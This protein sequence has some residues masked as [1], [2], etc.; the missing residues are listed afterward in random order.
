[1]TAGSQFG[2]LLRIARQTKGLSR[3]ELARM[4]ALDPSYL[5]RLETGERLPSRQA[6][7]ALADAL[8]L[9]EPE[10]QDWLMAAGYAPM[11]V[12]GLIQGIRTRGGSWRAG[13]PEQPVSGWQVLAMRLE[14]LG[15]NAATTGRLL[16][17]F[18]QADLALQDDAASWVSNAIA[19]VI[20]VLECPIRSAVIPIAG[21]NERLLA[22]HI[23]Q[24]LL[25]HV[26]AEAAEIGVTEV[27][28]VL[29]PGSREALFEPLSQATR[30]AIVPNLRLHSVEQS[31]PVGLGDAILCAHEIVGRRPF[32][33]LLP[34][35]WLGQRSTRPPV[36]DLCRMRDI[37]RQQGDAH[38]IAL[39]R[40]NRIDLLR[41][42]VA[43]LAEAPS[44]GS[45]YPIVRLVEKPGAE[46]E[47]IRLFDEAQ[48]RGEEK[49]RPLGI[50]GRY[51]LQPSVFEALG[52][53]KQLATRPLELT[54]ALEWV[55]R[56]G[57]RVFG[58][59]VEGRR[60]D[61]GGVV[62][63]MG[64]LIESR[65]VPAGRSAPRSSARGTTG[66]QEPLAPE[67]EL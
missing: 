53:L 49:G 33:V 64:E 22:S 52:A 34:D 10:V 56:K 47:I 21:S 40:M 50:V 67:K 4:A 41:S 45:A 43:Q 17:A 29:A 44:P 26:I 37:F 38:V 55:R 8:G 1:M 60:R 16:A 13:S 58:Y 65:Q 48:A 24:R 11:P 57:E 42:G 23:L 12:L 27:V 9:S 3:R 51:L 66:D 30:I 2:D 54:D 31:A 63:E 6:L 32:A 61:V 5:S 7:L 28:L 62:R 35:D 14:Q 25:L 59:V 15:L 18:A 36:A 46:H 39:D 19:R 20:Q